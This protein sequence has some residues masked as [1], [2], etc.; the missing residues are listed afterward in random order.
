MAASSHPAWNGLS[1]PNT[2]LQNS[3]STRGTEAPR[4]SGERQSQRRAGTGVQTL[5]LFK[6]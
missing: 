6:T 4:R 3:P 2:A 1:T 5:P